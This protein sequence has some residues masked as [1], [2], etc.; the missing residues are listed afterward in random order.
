MMIILTYLF[1][2]F[3]ACLKILVILLWII[4]FDLLVK[5]YF[6]KRLIILILYFLTAFL[7]LLTNLFKDLL[8]VLLN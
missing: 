8:T 7:T 1:I 2:Y 6:L 5:V 4:F 3:L